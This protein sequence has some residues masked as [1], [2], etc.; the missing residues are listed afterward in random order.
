MQI[1]IIVLLILLMGLVGCSYT[2][3]YIINQS[4]IIRVKANQNIT[5]EYDGWLLSDRAVDRIMDIKIKKVNL[6]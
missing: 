6:K 1:R 4:E 3:A 5:A 2:K